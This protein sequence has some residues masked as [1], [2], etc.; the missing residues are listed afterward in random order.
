MPAVV[1]HCGRY[2]DR[3]HGH[4]SHHHCYHHY[5]YHPCQS[6]TVNL[7]LSISVALPSLPWQKTT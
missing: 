7:M 6:V 5:F 3:R 4:I 1:D 2:Y